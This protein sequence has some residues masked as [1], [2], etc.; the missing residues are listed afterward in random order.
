MPARLRPLATPQN[1]LLAFAAIVALLHG[2]DRRDP[3]THYVSEYAFTHPVLL[4]AAFLLL[5]GAG[6]GVALALWRRGGWRAR[7][8]AVLVGVFALAVVVL[9]VAATDHEG[10][11]TASTTLGRVHDGASRWGFL[12]LWLGLAL[13][14]AALPRRK[15][16]A[17]LVLPGVLAAIF[18]AVAVPAALQPDWIGV[19]QRSFVGV[20]LLGLLL[21]ARRLRRTPC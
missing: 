17:A 18:L 9:A 12:A 11:G 8:A 16:L 4:G 19:Q 20:Q 14:L 3:R 6:A 15:L 21:L 5:A 1:G 10:R 13:G 7:P 2:L